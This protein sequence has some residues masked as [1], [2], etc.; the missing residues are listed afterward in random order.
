MGKVSAIC[1][2]VN[3]STYLLFKFAEGLF[4]ADCRV[5]HLLDAVKKRLKVPRSGAV[6]IIIIIKSF[7]Y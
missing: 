1:K 5:A 3:I 2:L 4:N 6:I 7:Y